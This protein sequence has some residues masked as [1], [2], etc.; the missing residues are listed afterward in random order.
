M[1]ARDID[2]D[3]ERVAADFHHLLDSA[4]RA[5]L[6]APTNGTR[7]TN[8]QPLFHM[9]FG[10]LVVPIGCDPYFKDVMTG[11]EL[12]AYPTQHYDHH[13]RPL[14]MRRG[15]CP[16]ACRAG[17]RYGAPPTARR[18]PSRFTDSREVVRGRGRGR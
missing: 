11:A 2:A 16:I 15:C 17:G 14:T 4:T 12:Y 1:D 10:V 18:S 5:E 8:Q 6:R 3:L 13:R 9:L 7:W